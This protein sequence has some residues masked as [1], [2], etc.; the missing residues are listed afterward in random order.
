MIDVGQ[1]GEVG[2]GGTSGDRAEAELDWTEPDLPNS[3]HGARRLAL[4]ALYCGASSVDHS[5]ESPPS[6]LGDIAGA[7][8]NLARRSGLEPE[9][10]AFAAHLV[11]VVAE[12]DAQ[13]SQLIEKAAHNWTL[14]RM[15]RLD[16]LILRLALAEIL[17][18]P[19][20]PARVSIDEAVELA[21]VYGGE[22]SYSF[23]NGILDAVASGRG[24]DV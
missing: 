12:H 2:D 13:L 3:R 9:Y 24:V 1:M 14:E 16:G 10:C 4:Q 15:A 22:T 19:D 7:L 6:R 23:V 17:H 18:V 5:S 20:V 8:D 11:T 21:K